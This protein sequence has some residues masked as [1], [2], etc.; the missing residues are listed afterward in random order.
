M[1]PQTNVDLV[2]RLWQEAINTHNLQKSHEFCSAN[3][4]H[5]DSS[6]PGKDI[7]GLN[8]YLNTISPFFTAF[9]DL[10][11]EVQDMISEGSKVASRGT[12]TGTHKAEL[13]GIPATGKRVAVSIIAI[14]R[15][16]RGKVVEGW[17]QF[18]A[19]GM[20]QQLGAIPSPR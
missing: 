11:L 10:R 20:M 15:V 2:N 16:S 12:F 4:L 9:P 1:P 3:Y 14:H 18:D 19:M 17:V 5:H 8:N 6:L 13:M 7:R